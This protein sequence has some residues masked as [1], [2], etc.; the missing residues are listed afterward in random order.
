VNRKKRALAEKID[1]WVME[2]VSPGGDDEQLL[3]GM[4]DYMDP[5]KQ[6]LDSMCWTTLS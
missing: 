2:V 6:L 5:F 1:A 4:Y 3:E